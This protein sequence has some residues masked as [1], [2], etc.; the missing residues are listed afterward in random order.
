MPRIVAHLDRCIGAGLCVAAA[1][2]YFTQ[3]DDDGT[4]IALSSVVSA[5]DVDMVM[6]AVRVC[7]TQ[8]LELMSDE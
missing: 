7:P 3:D 1:S 8:A 6:E 2:Q 4:V 5:E